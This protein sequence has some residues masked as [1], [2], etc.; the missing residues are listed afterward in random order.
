CCIHHHA[1]TFSADMWRRGENAHQR[2]RHYRAAD[3]WWATPSI[4][5]NLSSRKPTPPVALLPLLWHAL[6][7]RLR[8][9][10]DPGV[11]ALLPHRDGWRGEIRVREVADGNSDVSGK[12]F[13]LPVDG[14][15]ACRAEIKGKR[16]AAFGCPH[17]RR[18]FTGGGDLLTGEARLVA[19]H[20]AGAALAL[21]AVAH[22]DARWFALNRKVKLPATAG[23]VSDGH[24]SA[25]WLSIWRSVG[26][27]SKRC[28]PQGRV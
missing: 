1:F 28:T 3:P 12:A 5:T 19:D 21:L 18:S 13:V 10:G 8:R 14:G 16:V 6:G 20:G 17:P 25:P 11:A 27:T 23:G 26:W 24:G 2:R 4:F 7:R 9:Q 22:G 15:A